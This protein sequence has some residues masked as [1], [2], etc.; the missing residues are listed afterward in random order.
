MAPLGD[1][2]HLFVVLQGAS[3][4]H[5]AERQGTVPVLTGVE[6]L[7][8]A[9]GDDPADRLEAVERSVELR[10]EFLGA[11]H[12]VGAGASNSRG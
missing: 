4:A 10:S 7:S 8:T 1:A 12:A 2:G 11:A 6:G 9:F 5:P 3:C